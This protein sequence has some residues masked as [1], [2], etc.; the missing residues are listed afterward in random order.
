[1]IHNLNISDAV[2][3]SNTAAATVSFR[4][5][6]APLAIP[7]LN[8]QIKKFAAPGLEPTTL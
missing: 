1:M 5:T 3:E 8:I 7:K 2:Y 6:L 4:P